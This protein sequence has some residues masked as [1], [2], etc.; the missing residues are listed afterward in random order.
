MARHDLISILLLTAIAVPTVAAPPA[1][2]SW[3]FPAKKLQQATV[4]VR[5]WGITKSADAP[6]NVTICS[7][8]CI[9]NGLV[10]TAAFAGSDSPIRLT[11]PGGKQADAQVQV[12]DEFSGLV[13]LKA[14]T[15]GLAPLTAANELPAVGAELLTAAAWGLDQPLVSRG[16]VGAVDRKHHS[17]QYPPLLQTDCLTTSTSTGAGLVDRQGRLAGVIVATD[18]DGDRR[19]W[20]YA[21]P[22]S[23]V[24]RLL[25]A[26]DQ[27]QAGGVLIL[28]RRRPVVGMVLDQEGHAVVVS[29]VTPGGPAEK[30]G[31]QTGDH[32]SMTDGVVIRSVYQAVL[33]TLYKQPGDTTTFRVHRDETSR[34]ISVVL[35]GGVEVAS[36]PADLLADLV[37]PKIRLSRDP[38]GA[39]VTNQT[40]SAPP[41]VVVLP[42]LPDEAPPAAPPTSA[43]KIS[44]LEKALSRY[45]AVIEL[46]QKQ[47]ESL[48]TELE[49]LR[50][51]K[52]AP[53]SK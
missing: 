26:A 23:H 9:K 33:P 28:K 13:L 8:I 50:T 11:L 35:G 38:A 10:I 22:V 48:R 42:P 53:P 37:Q 5:I 51:P 14:D 47:L 12:I 39:I 36:A 21:V 20:A 16:I 46:Q 7:G 30:A 15:T 29:R 2:D 43:D 4:T 25:R 32:I 17:L 24:D 19:G 3:E 49:A 6:T 18:S 40:S 52:S 44:L 1:A 31:I 41:H 34:D 45:Q 27:Q